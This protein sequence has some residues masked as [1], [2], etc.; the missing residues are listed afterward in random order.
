MKNFS[1]RD[2]GRRETMRLL[3]I[4]GVF[5]FLLGLQGSIS[6]SMAV[7]DRIVAVVNQDIITLSEVERWMSPLLILEN[8]RAEDR[9]EKKE[10]IRE[11]RRKVLDQIIEDKLIEQEATRSGVKVS[12]KEMESALEEIRQRNNA[13]Q[14]ELEKALA[15]EGL[16]F[17]RYKK[18]IEK[19][20]QRMKVVQWAIKKE[21]KGG[22]KELVDF[23]QKNISRYR[24]TEMYR[25]RHILF[26]VP[27]GATPEQVQEAKKRCQ[28][29]LERIY[30]GE[31]FGEMALLY[32]EDISAKDRGDLGYFKKGEL[33][34]AFEREALRLKP[35]EVSGI[36]RTD[37]GFHIIK[38]VE[39][40]GGEP[41]SFEDVKE[42]VLQ[43]YQGDEIEKALKQFISTLREKSIIEIRL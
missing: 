41:L 8:V 33:L 42:K 37:Y 29:A 39:R 18:Q 24:S 16:T 14:E 9:L 6:E 22:E 3:K 34:P 15:S 35:G 4:A 26:V 40:R 17:D 23:Y 20:I 5:L 36:V 28:K 2:A 25:P 7:A 43:D 10:Q 32:S 1:N 38:L 31:D 27:K 11:L 12:A 13:T 30:K 21:A 19:Q